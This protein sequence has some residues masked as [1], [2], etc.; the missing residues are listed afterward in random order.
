MR[1]AAPA[2]QLGFLR[3]FLTSD[4]NVV[5]L[6]SASRFI[7]SLSA[8]S[9]S[10]QPNSRAASM[11]RFDCSLCDSA[12]FGF[13]ILVIPIFHSHCHT[14]TPLPP[15]PDHVSLRSWPGVAKR[16]TRRF[17]QPLPPRRRG[18]VP[19]PPTTVAPVSLI[20]SW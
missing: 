3:G 2:F 12:F 16:Q 20:G 7:L 6:L 1:R 11:K 10:S 5:G 4:F 15:S 8:S 14:Q 9:S 18:A 13:A 17:S 19:L